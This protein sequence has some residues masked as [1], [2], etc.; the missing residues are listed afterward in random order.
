MN[1]FSEVCADKPAP[2][3]LRDE[4]ANNW[5]TNNMYCDRAASW[6][7]NSVYG[8]DAQH[9]CPATC[10]VCVEVEC[11]DT[12]TD[13]SCENPCTYTDIWTANM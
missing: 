3:C 10:G 4:A 11:D 13:D 2:D 12:C 7:N 1:S 9:C 5:N 8:A 6:C